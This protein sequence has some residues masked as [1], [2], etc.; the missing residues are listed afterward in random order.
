MTTTTRA[1]GAAPPTSETA[2]RHAAREIFVST[3]R[4]A[5]AAGGV[6]DEMAGQLSDLQHAGWMASLPANREEYFVLGPQAPD[7]V[8]HLVLAPD[9]AGLCIVWIAVHPDA[10]RR[11]HARTLLST[12]RERAQQ[13]GTDLRLRV[14][15]DNHAAQALYRSA[16]F[17]LDAQDATDLHLCLP[18]MGGAHLAKDNA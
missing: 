1:A 6:P 5:L 9:E 17:G 13:S 18:T 8:G 2:Q 14:A 4:A 3:R 15:R 12:A 10:R 7:P 11:G 16:G